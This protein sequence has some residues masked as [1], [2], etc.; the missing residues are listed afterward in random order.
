VQLSLIDKETQRE[1][2]LKRLSV[3]ALF[4]ALLDISRSSEVQQP[5]QKNTFV[6]SETQNKK[7]LPNVKHLL[8]DGNNGNLQ[9]FL[10]LVNELRVDGYKFVDGKNVGKS[11]NYILVMT[12]LQ[13]H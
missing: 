12:H 11:V 3:L 5:D 10:H 4:L 9:K 7:L 2:M 1:I 13:S 6:N 8:K